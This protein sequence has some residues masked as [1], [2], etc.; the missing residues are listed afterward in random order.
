MRRMER[1]KLCLVFLTNLRSEHGFDL[2]AAFEQA[3]QEAGVDVEVVRIPSFAMSSLTRSRLKEL[4]NLVKEK[5]RTR[6][7]IFHPGVA[8]LFLKQADYTAV[9]SAYR[10]WYRPQTMRVIPHLR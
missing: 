4:Q 8:E 9:F 7:V 2:A 1:N 3:L 10:T 6:T 5:S